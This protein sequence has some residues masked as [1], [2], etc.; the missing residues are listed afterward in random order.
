MK[1]ESAPP[2]QLTDQREE[3]LNA[4]GNSKKINEF[5]KQTITSSMK[6]INVEINTKDKLN[7]L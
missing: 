2:P 3:N 4:R 5:L 6:Q 1:R 7:I